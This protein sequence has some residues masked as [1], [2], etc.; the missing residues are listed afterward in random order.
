MIILSYLC[1]FSAGSRLYSSGADGQV[2]EWDINTGK[3]V[4]N[5]SASKQAVT[6]LAISA[7]NTL[8]LTS[9]SNVKLW[10]ASTQ[11]LIARY[12]GHVSPVN[13]LEFVAGTSLFIS[14]A[15]ED[16]FL[17]VWVAENSSITVKKNKK[18]SAS[19]AS[20]ET[21]F[22]TTPASTLS[23]E[24]APL[25]VATRGAPFAV[26]AA[27]T[28]T[29]IATI[30]DISSLIS[31]KPSSS[32]IALTLP[33]T[34]VSVAG[35][36]VTGETVTAM[37]MFNTK[38][39]KQ[40]RGKKLDTSVTATVAREGAIAAVRFVGSNQ[41][42]LARNSTIHPKFELVTFV[43]KE[44]EALG[45]NDFISNISLAAYTPQHLMAETNS[46]KRKD[47][48]NEISKTS[49]SAAVI[50]PSHTAITQSASAL[51]A[52]VLVA[53]EAVPETLHA[54]R[55]KLLHASGD[56]TKSLAS[57][58]RETEQ[59]AERL[60]SSYVGGSLQTV[61]TQALQNDDDEMLEQCLFVG[62]GGSRSRKG[63][64]I[65][66]TI[67]RIAPSY[68]VPLLIKIIHKLQ[69]NPNRGLEL[70]PWMRESLRVHA[71]YLLTVPQ[72]ASHLSTLYKILEHRLNP[73][74]KLLT[75]Q[76]RLDLVL[77]QVNRKGSDGIVDELTTMYDESKDNTPSV[78]IKDIG[79]D[80]EFDDEDGDDMMGSGDEFDEETFENDED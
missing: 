74:K 49:F 9:G 38:N 28:N 55:M 77:S 17:N 48:S 37:S 79:F 34:R 35:E 10:N 57:R 68:V 19:I 13:N 26:V 69:G 45:E 23:L 22:Y 78:N 67:S 6:K 63:G 40:R 12:S 65:R 15:S 36:E 64:V 75:L 30:W 66:S 76:G 73:F 72:L 60:R 61:L 7:D 5:F 53:S 47:P 43:S 59:T 32:T 51:D 62:A 24:S 58:I 80:D 29:G 50:G 52:D 1:V 18:K 42:A 33:S 56:L 8:L 41:L 46:V 11:T 20:T 3:L 16:R 70:I 71:A 54:K 14:G 4:R 2:I 44:T 21:P 25:S 39:S 31:A 27:V